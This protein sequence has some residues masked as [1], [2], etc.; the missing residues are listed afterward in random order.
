[1]GIPPRRY[2]RDISKEKEHSQNDHGGDGSHTQIQSKVG[3]MKIRLAVIA[4]LY[5]LSKRKFKEKLKEWKVYKY[6]PAPDMQVILA[7]ASRRTTREGKETV[8][9]S[10]GQEISAERIE[11]FKKRKNLNGN[12]MP[13]PSAGKKSRY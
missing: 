4:N 13:S 2:L 5:I 12:T 10:N 1:M 3:N 7:K 11:N 9:Y 6:V 8:F